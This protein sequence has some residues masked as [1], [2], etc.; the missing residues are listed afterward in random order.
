MTLLTLEEIKNDE[1]F[2]DAELTI[3]NWHY[4]KVRTDKK[5][6]VVTMMTHTNGNSQCEVIFNKN[7]RY[8]RKYKIISP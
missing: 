1:K 4:R 7:L 2:I 6:R 8:E 5:G 3:G